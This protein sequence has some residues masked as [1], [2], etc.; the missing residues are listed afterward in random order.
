MP[1][2]PAPSVPPTLS[3]P[4]PVSPPLPPVLPDRVLVLPGVAAGAVVL[5]GGW[6]N[7]MDAPRGLRRVVA[8]GEHGP[9]L[10][11]YKPRPPGAFGRREP[12]HR[13][14]PAA[15][16]AAGLH[17]FASVVRNTGGRAVA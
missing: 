15:T 16:A 3:A 6:G 14:Y 1:E 2:P 11:V 17:G 10:R 12:P 4:P 8:R 5:P 7:D 9:A 13:G